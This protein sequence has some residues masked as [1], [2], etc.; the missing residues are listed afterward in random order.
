MATHQP[1]SKDL[2]AIHI[3]AQQ[4]GMDDAT[5]RDMLWTIA[6]VRSAKDLDWAGRRRVLEHLRACGAKAERPKRSA[7]EWAFVDAAAA[8][9]QPVLRRIIVFCRDLGIERGKQKAYVE[10]IARQMGSIRSYADGVLDEIP[11]R[12]EKPLEFC[13]LTELRRIAMALQYH[14]KRQDEARGR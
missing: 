3:A 9:R 1:R 11:G 14:Q 7:G 8:N 5:Y 2:A 12:V 10:G 6:R 4:L 13:D